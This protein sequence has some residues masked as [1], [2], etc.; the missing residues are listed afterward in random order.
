[1]VK[2]VKL[3]SH[4]RLWRR[5]MSQGHMHVAATKSCVGHVT[6]KCSRDKI[7]TCTH[8]KNEAEKIVSGALQGHIPRV[9]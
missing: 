1:M 5:D 8:M 3:P 9:N 4:E 7:K 6:V 2:V